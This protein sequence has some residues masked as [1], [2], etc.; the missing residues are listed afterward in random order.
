M[1][2]NIA[3]LREYKNEFLSHATSASLDDATF[4]E[5]WGKISGAIIALGG[6][7]RYAAAISQLK[8][9]Q[10][11]VEVKKKIDCL[12]EMM[13]SNEVKISQVFRE[14]NEMLTAN[15]Q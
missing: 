15:Q 5:Y 8:S 4:E 13:R 3:R 2:V 11:F 9:S 10:A 6:R 1:E 12:E 7:E 14:L